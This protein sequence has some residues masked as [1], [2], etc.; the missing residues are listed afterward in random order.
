MTDTLF[1]LYLAMTPI[2]GGATITIYGGVLT[3]PKL[4]EMAGAGIEAQIEAKVPT[5]DMKFA[6]VPLPNGASA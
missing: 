5:I 2:A 1:A 3:T 6:C 4:C